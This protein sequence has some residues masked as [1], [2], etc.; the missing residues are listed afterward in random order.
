MKLKK[1]KPSGR[2]IHEKYVVNAGKKNEKTVE[3]S[4][5]T[6]RQRIEAQDCT[7]LVADP[8]NGT[9]LTKGTFLT[10]ATY[11]MHGMGLSDLEDLDKFTNEEINDIGQQVRKI[12]VLSDAE[13]KS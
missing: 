10:M 9:L 1:D 7:V 11:A 8:A 2:I 5:L 4:R 13:K 12:S 6:V 3:L